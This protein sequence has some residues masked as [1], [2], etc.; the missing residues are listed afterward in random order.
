MGQRLVISI[1][2]NKSKEKIANSYYHWDGFIEKAVEYLQKIDTSMEVLNKENSRNKENNSWNNEEKRKPIA[3]RI[4]QEATKT[5]IVRTTKEEMEVNDKWADETLDIYIDFDE[6]EER[7]YLKEYK[8][9]SMPLLS[10]TNRS[11]AHLF[12]SALKG[13]WIEE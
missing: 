3:V 13:E 8:L 1:Y 9:S 11:I 12:A 10:A 2:D 7:M 4:L 6:D 5:T